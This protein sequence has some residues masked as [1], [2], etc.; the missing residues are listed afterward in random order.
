MQ[1]Q[2]GFLT[3][4]DNVG[5]REVDPLKKQHINQMMLL[6]F[7]SILLLECPLMQKEHFQYDPPCSLLSEPAE[8]ALVL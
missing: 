4:T 8:S 3:C 5:S 1:T 7:G 2:H 6:M